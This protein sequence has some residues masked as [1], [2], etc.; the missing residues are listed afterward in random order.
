MSGHLSKEDNWLVILLAS[1]Y[2]LNKVASVKV[3]ER[4]AGGSLRCCACAQLLEIYAGMIIVLC[5]ILVIWNYLMK[6]LSNFACSD[7]FH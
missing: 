4:I 7:I 1:W 6:C 2:P 5:T 3:P